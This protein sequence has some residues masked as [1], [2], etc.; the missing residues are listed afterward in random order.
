MR[1]LG[2][3][4]LL[5]TAGIETLSPLRAKANSRLDFNVRTGTFDE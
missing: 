1:I 5:E 3:A 2:L 4:F